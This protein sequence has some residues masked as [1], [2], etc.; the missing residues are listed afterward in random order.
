MAF[1]NNVWRIVLL[2][3]RTTT[4]LPARAR[5]FVPRNRVRHNTLL[6]R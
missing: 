3:Q 1:T 2:Q 6:R 5:S 4:A